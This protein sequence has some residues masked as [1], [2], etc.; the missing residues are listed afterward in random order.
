VNWKVF[1][2][3]TEFQDLER[4]KNGEAASLKENFQNVSFQF[5]AF[6]HFCEGLLEF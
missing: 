3:L 5:S 2:K 6:S 4:E 1:K